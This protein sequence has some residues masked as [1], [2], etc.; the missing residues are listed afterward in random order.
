MRHLQHQIDT[1]F[2]GFLNSRDLNRTGFDEGWT[3][4]TITPGLTVR[5]AGDAYEI[6]VQLPGVDKSNIHVHMDHSLLTLVVEQNLASSTP[7]RRG[8]PEQRALQ[9][10]RFERRLRLPGASGKSES[11]R[12]TYKDDVLTIRVPKAGPEDRASQ[13]IPIH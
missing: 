10:S 9:T 2:A 4:L 5:D 3:R 8:S 12:A 6:T 7:G 11:I 13:S 1:L